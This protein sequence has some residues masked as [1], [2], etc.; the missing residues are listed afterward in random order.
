MGCGLISSKTIMGTLL[1]RRCVSRLEGEQD[2]IHAET[3]E[4][5]GSIMTFRRAGAWEDPGLGP[6]W[7]CISGIRS[8]LS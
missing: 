2:V 7:Y 8:E 4:G 3:G 6:F 1:G 5:S